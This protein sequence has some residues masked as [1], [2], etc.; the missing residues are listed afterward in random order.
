MRQSNVVGGG[1][2]YERDVDLDWGGTQMEKRAD[3]ADT[4]VFFPLSVLIFGLTVCANWFL[5]NTVPIR[6]QNKEL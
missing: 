4:F 5:K 3:A 1:D 6:D 2:G